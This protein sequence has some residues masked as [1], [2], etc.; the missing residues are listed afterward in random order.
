MK[1]TE[2]EHKDI[3]D[4]IYEYPTLRLTDGFLPFEIKET[5]EYY[6]KEY[7]TFNMK[8][9]DDAMMGNTCGMYK[10]KFVIYHCD[11]HHAILCG[12]ENRD[13]KIDE[14]D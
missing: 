13:L 7:P 2:K 14:W 3:H 1:L 10:G 6:T 5:V 8:K 12:I 9:F 4:F 11:V